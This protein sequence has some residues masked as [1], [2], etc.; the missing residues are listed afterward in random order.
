MQ[1]FWNCHSRTDPGVSNNINY[2]SI[3]L[4]S[5]SKPVCTHLNIF[6]PTLT[7]VINNTSV[8]YVMTVRNIFF[9]QIVLKVDIHLNNI[10][11]QMSLASV[12]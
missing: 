1:T 4:K 11:L 6:Q 3:S 12:S 7:N 8:F 5:P 2:G 9:A 10:A